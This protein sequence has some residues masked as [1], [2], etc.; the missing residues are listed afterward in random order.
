MQ[1]YVVI[2]TNYYNKKLK[3]KHYD[4]GTKEILQQ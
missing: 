2:T 4:D 1:Y 3:T